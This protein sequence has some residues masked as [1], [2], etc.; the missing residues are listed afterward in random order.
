MLRPM[1]TDLATRREVLLFSAALGFGGLGLSRRAG[2]AP[3]TA[4]DVAGRVQKFYDE[5]KTFRASFVQVYVMKVQ[6]KKKQSKGRLVFEKPGKLSFRYDEPSGNRAV[7]DGKTMKVYE[8]ESEQMFVSAVGKS[9]YPAALAFLEGGESLEKNFALKLLD[10]SAMKFEGGFVLECVPTEASP[11]YAKMLVYVD[12]ETSQV[13]RVLLMDAQ[14]NRNRFD[15][16]D[17]VINRDVEPEE[18]EFTPPKGT[19][20][21]KP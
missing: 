17:P 11:V 4:A 15:F 18:F 14:G 20:L 3:L 9:Q 8:K 2:A 16:S 5:T 10:A 1:A 12:A 13:R 21:V 19:K 7:S 6:N